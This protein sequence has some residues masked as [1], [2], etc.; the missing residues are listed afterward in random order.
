MIMWEDKL[1]FEMNNEIFRG[2]F[3]NIATYLQ[4]VQQTI[5]IHI[6]TYT[7]TWQN[8][9]TKSRWLV[10]RTLFYYFQ[11]FCILKIFTVKI[12][13]KIFGKAYK[14]KVMLRKF[15]GLIKIRF[16]LHILE[17]N[18]TKSHLQKKNNFYFFRVRKK[19]SKKVQNKSLTK[20][21]V[22]FISLNLKRINKRH[23][24][25]EKPE[26]LEENICHVHNPEKQFL[27]YIKNLGMS[28]KTKQKNVHKLLPEKFTIR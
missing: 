4:M 21:L 13:K 6:Y 12:L 28:I 17:E 25:Q 7:N 20:G 10:C 11:S 15:N 8:V 23:Q 9:K 19:F 26:R 2:D 27:K 22:Y 14:Q 24:T 3:H 5:H 18:E 16:L 1:I